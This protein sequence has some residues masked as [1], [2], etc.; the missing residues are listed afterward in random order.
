[1]G[2]G[3]RKEGRPRK[4]DRPRESGFKKFAKKRAPF[5]LAAVTIAVVFVVP[6]LTKSDLQS[7]FPD[8][9]TDDERRVLDA[10][11]GYKGP[12]GKGLSVA[13]A[14][15]GKIG[16]EY[17][18]ERI[19]DNKKTSV[20]VRVLAAGPGPDRVLLNFTSYK[21]Q[22]DYSWDVDVGAGSVKGNNPKSDHIIDLVDFYD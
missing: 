20:D 4:E 17:P 15:S 11:M 2:R 5:Y 18:D 3:S 9:L 12:N 7:H 6:E 8:D 13:E 1:M 16:E 22:M 14:I 21:G 10:L 19:Y